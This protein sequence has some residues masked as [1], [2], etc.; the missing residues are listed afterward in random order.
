MK[1]ALEKEGVTFN[2]RKRI[3]DKSIFDDFEDCHWHMDG[4]R[5]ADLMSYFSLEVCGN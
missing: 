2:E 3:A 4:T 1:K 5:K